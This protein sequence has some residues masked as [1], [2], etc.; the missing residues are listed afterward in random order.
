MR[1]GIT[2]N[3]RNKERIKTAMNRQM[4]SFEAE[5]LKKC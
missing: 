3:D 4:S 1:E 2:G 5:G